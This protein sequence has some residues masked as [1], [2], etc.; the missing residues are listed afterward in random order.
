MYKRRRI[1]QPK[2]PT[3]ALEFDSFLQGSQYSANH[4]Q[5]IIYN[6][7]VAVIWGSSQM[8]NCL[9]N[10]NEIKFDARFKVVARL[11][12]QLFTIF[13]HFRGHALPALHILMNQ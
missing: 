6:D 12:Y 7:Q 8:V 2:L 3:S 9:R 11:F 1:L 13:I 4:V 10:A 5:T